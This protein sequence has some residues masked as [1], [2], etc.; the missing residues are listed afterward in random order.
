M[1]DSPRRPYRRWRETFTR[2][3]WD[4]WQNSNLEGLDRTVVGIFM[5]CARSMLPSSGGTPDDG[6]WSDKEEHSGK[7]ESSVRE[8]DGGP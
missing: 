6:A 2:C 7:V 5:A 4:L 3:T 1:T 8:M